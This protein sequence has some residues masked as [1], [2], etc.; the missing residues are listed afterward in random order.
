MGLPGRPKKGMASGAKAPFFLAGFMY[1]LKP[2]PS[3]FATFMVGPL[4]CTLAAIMDRLVPWTFAT[5]M[6]RLVP[7]ALAALMDGNVP[8][9]LAGFMDRLVLCALAGFM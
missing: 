7:C 8:S 9:T 1:G 4:P 5:F 3:T 6:D 2:V